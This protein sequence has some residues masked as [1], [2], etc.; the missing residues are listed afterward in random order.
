M[1][2]I[3]GPFLAILFLAGVQLPASAGGHLSSERTIP[4]NAVNADNLKTLVAAL[5]AADLIEALEGEGPFTVFAPTDDAFAKLP[6]G[7]VEDLLRPENKHQLTSILTYHVV[8]GMIMSSD[9][10]GKKTTAK[11]LQ[12][13]EVQIDASNGVKLEGAT[14]IAADIESSNGVIHIVDTV[15]MPNS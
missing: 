8:P 11:T 12:V 2:R 3:F 5:Q 4:T 1:V 15:I 9:L 10:A 6:D 14:V 7:T 13:D